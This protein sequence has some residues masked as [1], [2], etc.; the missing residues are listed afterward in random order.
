[1]LDYFQNEA[2]KIILQQLD[3]ILEISYFKKLEISK[4]L[5]KNPYF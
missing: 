5:E 4:E 1:M 2:H 3:D